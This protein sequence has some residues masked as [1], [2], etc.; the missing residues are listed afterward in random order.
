MDGFWMTDL[1]AKDVD[2]LMQPTQ[3]TATV[4]MTKNKVVM[5]FMI[6]LYFNSSTTYLFNSLP[7]T[8]LGPGH[9][10]ALVLVTPLFHQYIF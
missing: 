9:S 4:I 1:N 2:E 5:Y 10:L 3:K 8:H 7:R 6:Y